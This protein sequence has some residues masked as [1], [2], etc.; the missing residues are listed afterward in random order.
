MQ[1]INQREK[2]EA[3]ISKLSENKLSEVID[4]AC[5]LR[6]KEESDE[7]FRM[8]MESDSYLDWLSPDNDIYDKVFKNEI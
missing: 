4:F 8:Q 3:V 1:A 2:L 7:A 6:D 5:F